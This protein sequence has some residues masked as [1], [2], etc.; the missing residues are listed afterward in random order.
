MSLSATP[1]HSTMSTSSSHRGQRKRQAAQRA[2]SQVKEDPP[3]SSEGEG[4]EEKQDMRAGVEE[5]GI[6]ARALEEEFY[7]GRINYGR[8]V[9]LRH[10][11]ALVHAP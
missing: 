11:A 1:A 3:I 2:R 4:S 9:R 5:A 8:G 10:S 6:S 7:V